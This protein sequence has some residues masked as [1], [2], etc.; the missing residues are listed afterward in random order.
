MCLFCQLWLSSSL[1]LLLPLPQTSLR[2]K[3]YYQSFS[4]AP[5]SRRQAGPTTPSVYAPALSSSGCSGSAGPEMPWPRGH[6]WELTFSAGISPK[7]QEEKWERVKDRKLKNMSHK[8]S[9]EK[10]HK[11]CYPPIVPK[12]FWSF[13]LFPW[14]FPTFKKTL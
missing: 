11:A 12:E 10:G 1:V 4:P 14:T 13:Y 5:P 2:N 7:I 9:W 6:H 3:L 8:A